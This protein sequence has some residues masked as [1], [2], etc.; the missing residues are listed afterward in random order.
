MARRDERQDGPEVRNARDVSRHGGET[1]TVVGRYR[2]IEMPSKVPPSP[3]ESRPKDYAQLILEDGAVVY[4]ESYN[5]P[6]A[7]RPAAER[8]RF[9][10]KTVRVSGKLFR[11]MPASGESLVAPCVSGITEI[12]EEEEQPGA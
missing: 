6:Q 10:G 4:L 3:S 2:A 1:A 12:A 8:E 9:D 5:T 11:R 7:R